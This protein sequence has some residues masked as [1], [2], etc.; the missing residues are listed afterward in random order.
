[1]EVA[2]WAMGMAAWAVVL[3][4]SQVSVRQALAVLVRMTV[5]AALVGLALPVPMGAAVVA[6]LVVAARMVALMRWVR[7]AWM[8]RRCGRASRVE[9]QL[10]LA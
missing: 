9:S 3:A 2:E 6:Q 5:R 1:M 4:V 8:V 10:F 7:K